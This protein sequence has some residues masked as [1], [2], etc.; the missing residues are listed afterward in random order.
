MKGFNMAK[1][2]SEERLQKLLEKESQLKARINR[3][4]SRFKSEARKI[5]TRKKILLGSYLLSKMN[6]DDDF[7]DEMMANMDQYLTNDRD[8]ELFGLNP[9]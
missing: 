9:N 6:N 2:S 3:E 1:L 5:E 7:L 4:K 8:R